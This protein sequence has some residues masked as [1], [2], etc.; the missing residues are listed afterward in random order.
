MK[1]LLCEINTVK[2]CNGYHMRICTNIHH[3]CFLRIEEDSLADVV[4]DVDRSYDLI[5]ML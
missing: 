1:N 3:C 5:L 4:T 2:I